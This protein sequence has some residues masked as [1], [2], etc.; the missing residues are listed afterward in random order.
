M[1]LKICFSFLKEKTSVVANFA[2]QGPKKTAEQRKKIQILSIS[3][4]DQTY[5]LCF[6]QLFSI[7]NG[8][9]L[10]K[11]SSLKKFKIA[12][13]PGAKMIVHTPYLGAIKTYSSSL[14]LL[15]FIFY[16]LPPLNCKFLNSLQKNIRF[17]LSI[18][19]CRFFWFF[20]KQTCFIFKGSKIESYWCRYR[21][22]LSGSLLSTEKLL[23]N[24]GNL[25][26]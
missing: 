16:D 23:K 2:V 11:N 12:Y 3:I 25:L 17:G 7:Y 13:N 4:L 1:R 22:Y 24:L 10:F 26:Y 19:S 20:A 5:K 6:F 15:A 21:I 14:S 8:L 9:F 18:E